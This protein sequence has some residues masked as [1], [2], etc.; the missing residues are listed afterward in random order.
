MLR[1]RTLF[2]SL[3]DL[4][5]DPTYRDSD[6]PKQ[7]KGAAMCFRSLPNVTSQRMGVPLTGAQQ[8]TEPTPKIWGFNI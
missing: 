7:P 8:S 2:L 4:A 3:P 1:Q 5:Q 6:R